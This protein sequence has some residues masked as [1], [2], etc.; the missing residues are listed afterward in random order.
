MRLLGQLDFDLA[1][2]VLLAQ[3]GVKPLGRW[4]ADCDEATEM[5]LNHLG[6]H[7][8]GVLR[9]ARNGRRVKELVFSRSKD[10]V[11]DYAMLFDNS[12]L[13][14]P[15]DA[16]RAEGLMLGYPACCVEH[17]LAAGY[18]RN[19][20]P[21]RDQ[22]ILFHWACPECRVTLGLIE[23]YRKVYRSCRKIRGM[24]LPDLRVGHYAD[25][26]HKRALEIAAWTAE[27]AAAGAVLMASP[28]AM[29]DEVSHMLPIAGDSD[30][31]GLKDV[32]EWFFNTQ[33]NVPD[34]DGNGSPDGHDVARMLW[35]KVNALSR[36]PLTNKA[37]A[38]EVIAKGLVRCDICGEAVNMGFLLVVN[39]IENTSVA[40]PFLAIHFMEHGG[41]AFRSVEP[42]FDDRVDPCRAKIVVDNHPSPLF[43]AEQGVVTLHW[44]GLDDKTYQIH[45]NFD[46]STPWTPGPVYEGANEKVEFVDPASMIARKFYRLSWRPK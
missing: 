12:P 8:R 14:I 10:L 43:S 46:L 42:T 32:E 41:L 26:F 33:S 35:K 25:A 3:Q 16:V 9:T 36:T 5:V 4:E 6:L 21:R 1:Y 30:S 39:P 17:F 38:T 24:Q 28:H 13:T 45:T 31:D 11:R 7:H 44:H 15:P 27:I 18:A 19:G 2:L 40:L 23:A 20:L 22:R 37:Y 34:S 29:A